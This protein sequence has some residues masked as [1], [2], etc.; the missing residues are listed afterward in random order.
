MTDIS[1]MTKKEFKELPLRKWNEDVGEF[2]SLIILPGNKADMHDSGYRCMDFVAVRDKVAIC[3]LSGCSDVLHF[4]GI[5]GYG[6]DWGRRYNGC[7][8]TVPPSGWSMDCLPKS[9]LLRVWPN[10][11][12]MICGLALSSFSIYKK[13]D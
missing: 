8:T 7:P 9:G 3:R 6:H 2:D 13:G 4:D 1:N 10:N 11:Q 12:K 5:G